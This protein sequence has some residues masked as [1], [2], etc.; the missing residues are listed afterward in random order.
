MPNDVEIGSLTLQISANAQSAATQIDALSKSL[1]GLNAAVGKMQGLSQL[2]AQLA[3]FSQ[4]MNQLTYAV[5]T[6]KEFKTAANAIKNTVKALK[7]LETLDMG[8]AEFNL[9]EL[10]S[11]FAILQDVDKASGFTSVVNNLKKLPDVA[12]QLG[13]MDVYAFAA[14]IMNVSG[15][16]EPLAKQMDRVSAGFAAFPQ[17]LNAVHSASVRTAGGFSTLENRLNRLFSFAIARRIG[18]IFGDLITKSTQYVEDLNLFTVAMGNYADKAKEYAETVSETMGIDPAQWLRHQGVFQTLATGFGVTSDR[19]AIMSK[20]L[21]QLAYDLSSFYNLPIDKAMQKLESGFAGEIEPVRRLGY[22]LSKTALQATAASLGITKL[23]ADMT[24][25]EKSQLRYYAL[26]TQVTQVQG[27]MARTL[28]APANQLRILKAQLEVAARAI[29][30]IFIPLL[31]AVLPY[32]IAFAKFVR[33]VADAIANFFGYKLP[34]IDYS[35]VSAGI[36]DVDDAMEDLDDSTGRTYNRAKK[37]KNLLASFDELNII[38]SESGGGSGNGS[39]GIGDLGSSG[40]KDFELPEYDFLGNLLGSRADAILEK[41]KRKFGGLLRWV[42]NHLSEIWDVVKAIGIGL[43]GWKVGSSLAKLFGAANPGK[44]GL[45]IGLSIAGFSLE[46]SGARNIGAGKAQLWDYIKVALGSALGIGGSLLLFGT[47]PLG[48]TIGITAA[49]TV[50]IA[51]IRIGQKDRLRAQIES[52]FFNGVGKPIS[53]IANAYNEQMNAVTI[54]FTPLLDAADAIHRIDNEVQTARLSLSGLMTGLGEGSVITQ[55]KADEIQAAFDNLYTG[56]SDK[57]SAVDLLIRDSLITAMQ[58]AAGQVGIEVDAIL[59]E[60]ARITGNEEAH[61]RDLKSQADTIIASLPGMV[62]GSDEYNDAI[63]RLG[64]ITG[65][66]SALTQTM[67]PAAG[68]WQR[69]KE[70]L[71]GGV[72]FQSVE[73]AKAAIQSMAAT[74]QEAK[75]AIDKAFQ[76]ADNYILGKID[77]AEKYA[78]EE[79]EFWKSYRAV[80][81]EAFDQQKANIDNDFVD[82]ANVIQNSLSDHLLDVVRGTDS[83]RA[84]DYYNVAHETAENFIKPISDELESAFDRLGIDGEVWVGDAVDQ[85]NQGLILGFNSTTLEPVFRELDDINEQ[86]GTKFQYGAQ[87]SLEYFKRGLESKKPSVLRD[88]AN[89]G[90]DIENTLTGF[91][92]DFAT[93]GA[94]LGAGVTGGFEDGVAAINGAGENA[95]RNALRGFRAGAASQMTMLN[96]IGT[97]MGDAFGG[98]LLRAVQARVDAVGARL[99]NWWTHIRPRGGDPSDPYN[100]G[101]IEITPFATGGIP[102]AGSLFLAGEG[103]GAELV[104]SMGNQTAVANGDQI[105]SGIAYGVQMANASEERVLREILNT[106]RQIAKTG[107]NVVFSP[108]PEAGRAI[109]YAL[110]MYQT[111]RG[112]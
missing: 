15:A 22:D 34:E 71:S 110:N 8:N 37:L 84:E 46:F 64:A 48:W 80:N 77:Y 108:S 23:F 92:A 76:E 28:E 56:M 65:E 112:Y 17:K 94:V 29:G 67:S 52:E 7:E 99:S 38:Q 59:G 27:D 1:G 68:E 42:K 89:I 35:G 87:T 96:D 104:G 18:R 109:Q 88:V 9:R 4:D 44:I 62:V 69:L 45:G 36:G 86:M 6:F 111:Q 75:D 25:A 70:Q 101:N 105:V 47:G 90:G 19:A 21:T 51:G 12:K 53:E 85:I 13:E 83:E 95:G 33:L 58:D 103:G 10:T 72:D 63:E 41:F 60:L 79:V 93:A 91:N 82:M 97:E 73:D 81:K 57:L 26:M 100:W 66:M 102:K 50:L 2:S 24:Q 32:L 74:S 78:P 98:N 11:T 49:L 3:K 39:G 107:G 30:N 14:D 5:G 20:N 31:N 43:L 55:E 40:W 54:R 61:L 106:L 16:L